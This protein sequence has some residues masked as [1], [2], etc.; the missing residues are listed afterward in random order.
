MCLHTMVSV[1]NLNSRLHLARKRLYTATTQAQGNLKFLGFA[2][3]GNLLAIINDNPHR[4]LK[5]RMRSES[6][7]LTL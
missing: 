1:L 2:T 3:D 6:I 5:F 7:I 4:V